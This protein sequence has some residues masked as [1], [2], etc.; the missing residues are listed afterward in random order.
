MWKLLLQHSLQNWFWPKLHLYEP[1]TKMSYKFQISLKQM[2]NTSNIKYNLLHVWITWVRKMVDETYKSILWLIV[3]VVSQWKH[4]SLVLYLH[5]EKFSL[6]QTWPCLLHN[7]SVKRILAELI[8][9]ITILLLLFISKKFCEI[10][11]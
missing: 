6:I 10:R 8:P 9:S 7:S 11:M 5:D 2:Y 1:K 4:G 3:N